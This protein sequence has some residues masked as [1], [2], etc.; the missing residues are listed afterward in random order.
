MATLRFFENGRPWVQFSRHGNRYTFR[1]GKASKAAAR[2]AKHHVEQLLEHETTGEPLPNGTSRWLREA[3]P[4]WRRRLAACGLVTA[5]ERAATLEQLLEYVLGEYQ[6]KK[7]NTRRNMARVATALRDR[8]GAKCALEA[9]TPGAAEDFRRWIRRQPSINSECTVSE[10]CRKAKRFFAMA[11]DHRWIDTN[12][13]AQMKE[14]TRSNPARAHFVDRETIDTVLDHCEPEWALIVALVRFAG[15][16]CPSEVAA[17]RWDAIHWDRDRMTIHSPKTEHIA[18]KGARVC[19]IFPE[20]R[21]HLEVAWDRAP[22]GAEFV[23]ERAQARGQKALYSAF[24]KRLTRAGIE[25]WPRLMTNLR[26]SRETELAETYPIHVVTAWLGNS[27]TI[28]ATHYLQVTEDHFR[29]AAAPQSE[30]RRKNRRN[31]SRK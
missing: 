28:A 23:V 26:A 24:L 29:Q 22:E 11:V 14:W 30:K 18:T 13:F 21:P 16:R 6:D 8:F 3:S 9:I 4:L 1:L 15:L 17:L 27:P 19:P 7:P 2:E 20:V 10:M 12:P 5:T 25:A 31:V